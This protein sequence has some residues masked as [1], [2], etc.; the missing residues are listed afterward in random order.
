[1]SS[2]IATA[3][4]GTSASAAVPSRTRCATAAP[5][6]PRISAR[7][8]DGLFSEG[9]RALLIDRGG[10]DGYTDVLLMY[11]EHRRHGPGPP[12]SFRDLISRWTRGRSL[13]FAP[14]PLQP[15]ASHA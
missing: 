6:S 14:I 7:P 13:A 8:P 3:T 2:P 4:S 10:P 11:R 12:V 1:S 9:V 15:P 5:A